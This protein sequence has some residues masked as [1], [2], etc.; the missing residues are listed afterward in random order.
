MKAGTERPVVFNNKGMQL[1]GMLHRP[2]T[3]EH[4]PAVVFFHGC[5]GDRVEKHWFFVKIARSLAR[6]GIMAFR[7]D[8]RYSGE[9]EGDFVDMTFS[10]E[11][12]DGIR[13]VDIVSS[14]YGADPKRIGILGLSMGGAVGAVV[15]GR[16]GARIASCV[17]I[18]PVGSPAEDT[19]AF[20]DAKRLDVARF[21]VELNTYLFGEAFARDIMTIKP[22]DEIVHAACPFLI[23]NGSGDKSIDPRRS[24]EYLKTIQNAE[25]SAELTIVEGADHVF[26]TAAWENDAIGR[27][28]RWFSNTL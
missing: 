15:A 22:M 27:V 14:E 5:T 7:F 11:V 25:G 4:P 13:A 1:V 10:G 17:L 12:S 9:S 18:N 20:A 16:L 2:D 6:A 28:T 8:F 26:S 24:H 23:V 21:P 3:D 19:Q